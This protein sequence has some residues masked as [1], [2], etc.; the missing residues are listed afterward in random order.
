MMYFIY[1]MKSPEGHTRLCNNCPHRQWEGS[2]L[3]DPATGNL[4]DTKNRYLNAQFLFIND[5]SETPGVPA[6]HFSTTFIDEEGN[7]T[8]SLFPG[9]TF[10]D[11]ATCNGPAVTSVERVRLFKRKKNYNCGAEAVRLVAF[12]DRMNKRK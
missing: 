7:R 9:T 2:E 12:W 10:E 5:P 6:D 4:V 11:I 1:I 3:N 8:A